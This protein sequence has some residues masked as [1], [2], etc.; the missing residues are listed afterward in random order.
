MVH[1]QLLHVHIHNI[2]VYVYVYTVHVCTYVI[3]E[4]MKNKYVFFSQLIAPGNIVLCMSIYY[5][6]VVLIRSGQYT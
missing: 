1:V 4:S 3:F 5:V 2:H 6:I